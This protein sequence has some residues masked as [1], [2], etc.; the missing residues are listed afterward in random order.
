MAVA[1]KKKEV[2]VMP[3]FFVA[4]LLSS[5]YCR[6]IAKISC[7]LPAPPSGQQALFPAAAPSCAGGGED[8]EDPSQETMGRPLRRGVR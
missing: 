6:K 5:E 1:A 2:R 8:R 4:T 3:M 7:L